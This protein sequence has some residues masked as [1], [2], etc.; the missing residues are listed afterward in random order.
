MTFEDGKI[1][2]VVERSLVKA[3]AE[4][5]T[6]PKMPIE[7]KYVEAFVN[8]VFNCTDMMKAFGELRGNMDSMPY[9]SFDSNLRGFP[10]DKFG[11]IVA[12]SM[13]KKD[14][15]LFQ[16]ILEAFFGM[17]SIYLDYG[18]DELNTDENMEGVPTTG[19]DIIKTDEDL[20]T[21]PLSVPTVVFLIPI[22][23]EWTTQ[24]RYDEILPL[25]EKFVSV[26]KPVRVMIKPYTPV[27]INEHYDHKI[28]S[29]IS[30]KGIENVNFMGVT[31]SADI[32]SSKDG[33]SWDSISSYPGMSY[34]ISTNLNTPGY[35]C[36]TQCEDNPNL[37]ACI[38]WDAPN[39]CRIAYSTNLLSGETPV[40]TE[41]TVTN[42]SNYTIN[43]IVYAAKNLWLAVGKWGSGHGLFAS[44]TETPTEW[45]AFD[46]YNFRYQWTNFVA[47]SKLDPISNEIMVVENHGGNYSYLIRFTYRPSSTYPGFMEHG[48]AG[49]PDNVYSVTN[50]TSYFAS[51][52]QN[53]L[54]TLPYQG[55]Y[56]ITST[57]IDASGPHTGDVVHVPGKGFLVG[58]FQNVGIVREGISPDTRNMVAY[59]SELNG[60]RTP[61]ILTLAYSDKTKTA[62]AHTSSI[63]M[64]RDATL[65]IEIDGLE[66]DED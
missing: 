31:T 2:E 57:E 29:P 30:V 35:R 38:E 3:Y 20:T 49:V 28:V 32:V 53:H 23:Y 46:Y 56:S 18:K 16:M 25:F 14:M 5:N 64:A 26:V 50:G 63:Y 15:T 44:F 60:G 54:Y 61:S 62:V 24:E 42:A 55:T 21:D 66:P 51:L 22:G 58:S 27:K 34:G 45:K 52:G 19:D 36:I 40:W 37:F 39:T 41:A 10:T 7:K 4:R 48:Y 1:K 12:Y 59:H 13:L 6:S 17:G 33:L 43:C 65:L 47:V 9:Y 8:A 11:H